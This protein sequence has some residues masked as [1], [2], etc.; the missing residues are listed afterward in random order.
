MVGGRGQPE[1]MCGAV[2]QARHDKV[3][4]ALVD[5]LFDAMGTFFDAMDH[6]RLRRP[7]F[8]TPSRRARGHYHEAMDASLVRESTRL[9]LLACDVTMVC[10]DVTRLRCDG[11]LV[12][13]DVT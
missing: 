2:L 4:P 1:V 11:T 12:R 8:F 7:P 13:S 5:G 9:I 6:S 10:C 3:R